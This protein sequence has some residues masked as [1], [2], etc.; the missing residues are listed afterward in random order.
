MQNIETEAKR[1]EQIAA[2]AL[3]KAK[4]L[5]ASAAELSVSVSEGLSVKARLGE[6]DTI[7]HHRDKSL[8]ITVYF[9]QKKASASS[10][11]FTDKA[12]QETVSA[13]CGIAQYTSE[14]S[15]SG[16]A[17]ATLMA[18]SIADLDLNHPWDLN[19]EQAIDMALEMEEAARTFDPRISNTGAANVGRQSAISLYSNSHGFVG[20][21]PRT[22]HGVSCSVIAGE[23]DKMQ[24]E[25]WSSVS[26][27]S[28]LLDDVG[29]VGRRAAKRAIARLGAKSVKTGEFP[30]LFSAPMARGILAAFISS[31]SGGALYRRNTFMLDKINQPVFADHIH[32]F[33]D[34]YIA[35]ALGSSSFDGD[36]LA[37]KARH[38]VREGVL[39]GYVLSSYSAR[40]LKLES[41]A[42]AGGVRNL[43]LAAGNFNDEQ[44]LEQLGTGLFVTEM[45]GQ[46]VKM[47]S[48]DYSRGASGFWVENGK[49]KHAV[50]EVTVAGN[51]ASMFMDITAVGAELDLRGNIRSPSI[52]IKQMMVAG[53]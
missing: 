51:L 20:L 49:I 21:V 2:L 19:A 1:I 40:K 29:A 33:E 18:E 6:V 50:Q 48:G 47:S 23:G 14:D 11:D 28:S 53:K 35:Q 13:A 32:L 3:D 44:M 10:S 46:G 43:T 31:I 12:V 7:E 5:G 16:L 38:I 27:V 17:D 41:T 24:R 25:H 36:G 8:G 26:R 22:R 34:P 52:L 15:C 37:R 30:V 39:Q 9:G 4:R 42:N 45:M